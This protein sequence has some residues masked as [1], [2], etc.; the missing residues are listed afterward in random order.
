MGRATASRYQWRRGARPIQAART[1]DRR[2]LRRPPT[3]YLHIGPPKTGTTYLQ[4]V[5]WRNEQ[6]LSEQH[7]AFPRRPVDHFRAALDL[8]GL[9][10]GGYDDPK[11]DGAWDSFAAEVLACGKD[12]AVVSHEVLAAATSEQIS[13]ALA[14]LAPAEVH[15]VYGVRDLARQLPAVWQE[16]LKN[17]RTRPY[18]QF[19]DIAL[20]RPRRRR[21]GLGFWAAQDP[22]TVLG[23]WAE[24]VPADRIHVITIPHRSAAADTLWRRFCAVVGIDPNGFDLDVARSNTSLPQAAAEVLRRLNEALP[25]DLPWPE[26]ER[27]I[28]RR[29]NTLADRGDRGERLRVPPRHR[30]KVRALTRR[31]QSALA[32]SPYDV[33]GDLGELT[34]L[35]DAFGPVRGM[36]PAKAADA[37]VALLAAVLIEAPMG[38]AARR[39]HILDLWHRRQGKRGLR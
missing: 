34:P 32:A 36:S 13:R 39:R 5:L 30:E 18:R 9:D 16:S 26:Y 7:V 21:R 6:R 10:F 28:K 20:R 25:N 23:R 38:R 14:S 11:T 12:K 4:E 8:R 29:F 3:I 15:V 22:L 27:L 17:R 19:L 33:V 2:V 35:D 37:A 1:Y 31:T 24:Q